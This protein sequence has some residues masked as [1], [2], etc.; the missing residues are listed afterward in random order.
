MGCFKDLQLVKLLSVGRQVRQQEFD[1]SCESH[2][3][4][5]DYDA[6]AAVRKARAAVACSLRQMTVRPPHFSQVSPE[7][8]RS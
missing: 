4:A 7:A 2:V 5:E 1:N 3:P 6:V 8:P